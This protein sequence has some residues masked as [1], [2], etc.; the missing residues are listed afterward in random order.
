MVAL[1]GIPN[2]IKVGDYGIDGRL[3]LADI[4]KEHKGDFFETLDKWYPI[5]VKRPAHFIYLGYR[6]V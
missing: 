3:Y 6:Q 5:Q 2:Q 4:V 1:G